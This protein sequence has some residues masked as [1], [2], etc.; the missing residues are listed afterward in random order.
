M[1]HIFQKMETDADREYSV[2]FSYLQIY[3]DK[4]QDLMNPG[5]GNLDIVKSEAGEVSIPGLVQKECSSRERFIELYEEGDHHRIVAATKMN[6]VSSRSHSCLMIQ[7]KSQ[8]K[9]DDGTGEIRTAKMWM[10]DLAGY[11]RFSKTGVLEGIRKEEAK[12]INASLLSL[13]NV[14]AAL[15]EKQSHIPWRN[16]KLTR[17]L[18]DAIGGKAKASVCIT[19][20]PSGASFHETVGTLYFG[21][22]VPLHF[23]PSL[24]PI[25]TH[26]FYHF[27]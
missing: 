12:G 24:L 4:V 10:I 5:Q 20:G 7:I 26:S 17:L 2:L 27:S 19:L 1:M 14:I 25:T 9:G 23:T 13:G 8:P 21:R 6:P 15:S 11:E 3:L 18:Q 16:A 22:Y